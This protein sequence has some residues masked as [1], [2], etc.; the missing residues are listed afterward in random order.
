MLGM[1]LPPPIGERGLRSLR[2]NAGPGVEFSQLSQCPNG[3]HQPHFSPNDWV[4]AREIVLGGEKK[5]Q[6]THTNLSLFPLEALSVSV[7][8]AAC[9]RRFYAASRRISGTA[10]GGS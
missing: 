7:C 10:S 4:C 9:I 8:V 1:Q 5:T 3:C 2:A 6:S